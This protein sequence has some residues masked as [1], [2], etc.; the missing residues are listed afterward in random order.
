[1]KIIFILSLLF[2]LGSCLKESEILIDVGQINNNLIVL[3]DTSTN[4]KLYTSSTTVN[5]ENNGFD[6]SSKICISE[7]QT[8][9]P[10]TTAAGTCGG[11]NWISPIPTSFTLS[12]G[13]GQKTVYI[14]ISDSSDNI[15]S[16]IFTQD[17]TLDIS[18]PTPTSAPT[19]GTVPLSLSRTPNITWT[20]DSTDNIALEG[21]QIKVTKFSDS[22]LI[23]DWTDFTKG[24]YISGITLESSTDY[25]VEIRAIDMAGNTST[26]Q[27]ANY[28]SALVITA[29]SFG[30][31]AFSLVEQPGGAGPGPNTTLTLTNTTGSATG[32]LFSPNLYGGA[33]NFQVVNDNCTGFSLSDGSSCTVDIRLN[34]SQDGFYL[35]TIYY[36]DGVTT[37]SEHEVRGMATGFSG[38]NTYM[39]G[40]NNAITSVYDSADYGSTYPN[41]F[42]KMIGGFQWD[43]LSLSNNFSCGITTNAKLY[44]W[45]SGTW[46]RHGD[47][48]TNDN[49]YPSIV[50]ASK[51]W[52]DVVV[53][54]RDVCAID[55]TDD[56]YCWGNT[57]TS[58]PALMPGG[59]KWKSI[60]STRGLHICG[61]TN[62][63]DL[64]C[65][66]DNSY[67]QIGIGDNTTLTPNPTQVTPG[68]KYKFVSVGYR[69]TCAITSTDLTYCW[70]EGVAGQLGDGNSADTYSP[71]LVLGGHTFT[72]V[73]IS[74]YHACGLTDGSEVYC[75]GG[76]TPA[77]SGALGNGLGAASASPVKVSG[78][79]TWV[80]IGIQGQ[81]FSCGIDNTNTMYC[82]GSNGYGVLGNG[83]TTNQLTPD[84]V[85]GSY[86]WSK[87][88]MARF[89][90]CA[91][92]TSNEAYC[93][94]DYWPYGGIANG[95][96]DGG[97]YVPKKVPGNLDWK[98]ISSDYENFCGIISND[99]LYCVGGDVDGQLGDG[100]ANTSQYT[101]VLVSGG[102]KWISVTSTYSTTCGVT[103]TNDAYCWGENSL[104]QAGSGDATA[105]FTTPNLVVGG[106][107]WLKVNNNQSSTCGLRTDGAAYCWG[108]NRFGQLGNGVTTGDATPFPTPVAV[109]G[110]HIFSDISVGNNFACGLTTG[111]DI[112][113]WGR[114]DDGQ[115]G[116][117]TS[118]TDSNTPVQ[119]TGGSGIWRSLSVGNDHVCA[120]RLDNSAYCWGD[121][122][123]RATGVSTDSPQPIIVPGGHSWSTFQA[124]LYHSCGL[125]NGTSD[126]YC[127]GYDSGTETGAEPQDAWGVNPNLIKYNRG[128][129]FSE[130]FVGGANTF[131]IP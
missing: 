111:N 89:N 105:A 42:Y 114:D 1:M 128:I 53:A 5:V 61:I 97:Y 55:S 33:A 12:G 39:I 32:P 104:G 100:G 31:E 24:S 7:T 2:L 73:D 124:G 17:I 90:I 10:A 8:T 112:Y 57:Y 79:Q 3:E 72:K 51:T 102:H 117:D 99:D 87:V 13:D 85:V 38:S 49:Y 106:H 123:N 116:N 121:G 46:G 77:T 66:G 26:V 80:D 96:N 45:G 47:G 129:K 35:T 29:L 84:L 34:A 120:V 20:T 37:S 126:M 30:T 119:V 107:S 109:S 25:Q 88:R 27:S 69:F 65:W 94:G 103:T 16:E 54:N 23:Q 58:T 127:F 43:E 9:L 6:A 60:A 95:I 28:T 81:S 130:I 50:E 56:L 82:W 15:S 36:T 44:C 18:A 71:S 75:W 122:N 48:T 76:G 93:W 131:G 118:F 110:G 4:S 68:T 64:Y 19:F 101:P 78:S 92:T 115:L 21:Y 59:L 63:D 67:G 11:A 62:T 113:C 108:S 125:E 41:E 70:G 86:S 14:Y 52:K 83:N 74:R 91:I 98:F 22:T 40:L